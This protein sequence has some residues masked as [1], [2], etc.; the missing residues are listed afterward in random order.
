MKRNFK[1]FTLVECIIALAVLAIASLTMAQ[2]YA[3]VSLRNRNN[4]LMNTSLSNQMAYVEKYTNSEATPIYFKSTTVSG[5]EKS[6]P[7]GEAAKASTTKKPPHENYKSATGTKPPYVSVSWVDN[8][9]GTAVTKSYSYA[10]DIFIL[11]NRDSADRDPN[12]TGYNGD[13]Q[14]EFDLRYKYVIG[15][16]NS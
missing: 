5:K 4:H 3:S 13:T 12:D 1:G 6:V 7:D 2:I 15:H 16:K 10:A 9:S 8:S 14:S 11:Q